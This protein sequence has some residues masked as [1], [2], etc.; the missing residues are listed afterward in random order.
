MK[1]LDKEIAEYENQIKVLTEEL[2]SRHIRSRAIKRDIAANSGVK[3]TNL[4]EKSMRW[5]EL[6]ELKRIINETIGYHSFNWRYY[7]IDCILAELI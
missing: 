1:H 4:D 3:Q 6:T 7:I 2:N 5:I